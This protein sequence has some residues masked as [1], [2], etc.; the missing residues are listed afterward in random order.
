VNEVNLF[1]EIPLFHVQTY[2]RECERERERE[3]EK[4]RKSERKREAGRCT[5]Q[6]NDGLKL[7]SKLL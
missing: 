1:E 3:R 6:R 7:K 2:P 5:T 4:E